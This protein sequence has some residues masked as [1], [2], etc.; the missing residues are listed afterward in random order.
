M[1]TIQSLQ[2]E[3]IAALK[4]KDTLRKDTLSSV[5]AAVKKVA[6]D[7]GCRDNITEDLIIECIRK[8]IKTLQEQIDTCPVDRVELLEEFRWKKDFLSQY[9]PQLVT[10]Y[11]EIVKMVTNLVRDITIVDKGQLMK[12]VM[13]QL[14]GKVDMKIAN[15]VVSD[16]FTKQTIN[17]LFGG[18]A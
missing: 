4:E 1:I 5:I 15:Q 12:I 17:E 8:E 13:P 11:D 3:M 10:D 14:K 6:I 18:E 2:K 16:I 7:K 9:V